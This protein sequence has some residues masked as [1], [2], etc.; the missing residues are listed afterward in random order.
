MTLS[1]KE[2]RR[3][4][5]AEEDLVL[6]RHVAADRPFAA[7]DGVMKAWQNLADTVQ[8]RFTALVEKHRR[9]DIE[10]AKQSGVSEEEDERRML[11]DDIIPLL[12]DLKAEADSKLTKEKE[13]NMET[14]RKRKTSCGRDG[15]DGE[16]NGTTGRRASLAMAIEIDGA[17]EID[18]KEKEL[19]FKWFKYESDVR[20]RELDRAESR[21]A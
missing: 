15:D 7:E 2:K 1:E 12:N 5:S 9:G 13:E 3:N 19:A 17:R 20:Q 21:K 18:V 8:N 16:R 4:W 14:M 10:S 11:L 6:L